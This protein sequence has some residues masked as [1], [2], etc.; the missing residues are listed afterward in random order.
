MCFVQT[1]VFD[2]KWTVKRVPDLQS[3]FI[4][5]TAIVEAEAGKKAPTTNQKT[6]NKTPKNNFES[7]RISSL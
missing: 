3:M 4:K 1:V 5:I 2:T 6:H 7:N